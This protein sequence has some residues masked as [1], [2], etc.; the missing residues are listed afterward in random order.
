MLDT[1]NFCSSQIRIMDKYNNVY[2]IDVSK[3]KLDVFSNYGS[4]YCFSNN[5][6]GFKELIESVK[7]DGLFVMEATG[8]YH[9][10]LAHYLYS[11]GIAV[12]VVNPLRIKRFTQMHLKRNKTD[13][14]DAKMIC[15][16]GQREQT[17]LYE[18]RDVKLNSAKD[19]HRCIEQFIS[20]RSDLKRKLS[21]L[22]S[23]G[24][25]SY[26]VDIIAEEIIR[27]SKKI[28][29]LQKKLNEL[30]KQYDSEMLTLLCSIK[31]IG[32]VT[33]TLL[34]IETNGFKDFDCAKKL[35]SF[36][37]LAPTETCSGTSVSGR[38]S[39]SKVGNPLVRQKLYMCSLQASRYNAGCS[40][41][42]KRLLA[43][44]KAKK[45]A[46]IAVGNKLLKIVMA[47]VINKRPYDPEYRSQLLTRA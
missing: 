44:G 37:G 15:L 19:L 42:Y 13:K 41:L 25:D 6:I 46:L 18:P 33:A 29:E 20:H 47:V 43:K 5:E 38:R 34:I 32:K 23:K 27:L 4:H 3:K 8:I 10:Q 16:Y 9:F 1:L 30:I 36:F 2:G 28:K 40:A 31:G 12:S 26:L 11:R 21:G 7:L 17:T 35:A 24:A 39:I 45:L 22:K 14:A